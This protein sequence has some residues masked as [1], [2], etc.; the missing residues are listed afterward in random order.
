MR[1]GCDDQTLEFGRMSS[2]SLTDF[3][4][5][6]PSAPPEVVAGG[7]AEPRVEPYGRSVGSCVNSTPLLLRSS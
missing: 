5:M 3:V 2:F 6:L 7:V 1:D 4:D